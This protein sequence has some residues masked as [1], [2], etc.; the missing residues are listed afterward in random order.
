MAEFGVL[1]AR[2]DG[3]TVYYAE[4]EESRATLASRSVT[5]ESGVTRTL[6]GPIQA[7]RYHELTT[8]LRRSFNPPLFQAELAFFVDSQSK[9]GSASSNEKL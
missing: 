3:G 1:M 6:L 2:V 5:V 4:E 7:D 9:S 8:G